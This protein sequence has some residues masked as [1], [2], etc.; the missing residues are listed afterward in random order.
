MWRERYDLPKRYN[1]DFCLWTG[2]NGLCS[3]F[4]FCTPPAK[5]GC[6]GTVVISAIYFYDVM[7]LLKRIIAVGEPLQ[8]NLLVFLA[9]ISEWS[10]G[11]PCL[12]RIAS[13]RSW[14]L[15][16]PIM[17]PRERTKVIAANLVL[18]HRVLA[19][20]LSWST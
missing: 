16:A 7:F 14:L 4:G 20:F 5:G 6:Y 8:L 1:Y 18:G 3:N 11:A 9:D 15:V 19:V 10:A 13:C 12:A 2:P 17:W